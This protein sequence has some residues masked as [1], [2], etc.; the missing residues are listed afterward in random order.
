M[1]QLKEASASELKSQ[2]HLASEREA[3]HM[4]SEKMSKKIKGKKSKF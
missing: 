3:V 1:G 2:W 4:P